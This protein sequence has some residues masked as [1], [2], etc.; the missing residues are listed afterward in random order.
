MASEN[1]IMQELGIK[2][3]P[4]NVKPIR[5]DALEV[6]LTDIFLKKK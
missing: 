4:R 1:L 5:I 3:T 2:T 6:E